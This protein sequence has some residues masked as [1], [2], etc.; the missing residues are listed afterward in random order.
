MGLP[1]FLKIVESKNFC[2][3]RER[4]EFLGIGGSC[5]TKSLCRRFADLAKLRQAVKMD[6]NLHGNTLFS[7]T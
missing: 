5:F 1:S 2:E 6:L 3:Y 4:N 7:Q